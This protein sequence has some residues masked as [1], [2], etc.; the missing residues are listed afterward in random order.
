VHQASAPTDYDFLQE[1]SKSMHTPMR[2]IVS[3]VLSFSAL[4]GCVGGGASSASTS[5]GTVGSG[6]SPAAGNAVALGGQL[7]LGAAVYSVPS[8]THRLAVSVDRTGGSS[9]V[10]YASYSTA[11]GSAV[12]GTDF[13]T[14]AGMLQWNDG[15][16]APK[17][18]SVPINASA[19]ANKSF[20]VLLTNS[21]GATL[22][23]VTSATVTIAG[24][25][26]TSTGT[27][28][29]TLAIHVR[30][31]LLEDGSGAK[32]QL[33]GANVSGLEGTAVQG[34]GTSP[35]GFNNWADAGLGTEPD[36]SK[37]VAWKMNAVRIPLNETSWLGLACINPVSRATTNP[38]PGG[39][40]RATVK[41]SIADA[42]AA[43][44][45]VI[46]DLHWSAPGKYCATGQAQMAN[47]DNSV[48]F[49]TSIANSFKS[50]PAVIFELFNEPYGQGAYPVASSD[51]PILR[52]GGTYANFVHQDPATGA[53][54]TTSG[55][56]QA[57]GMQTML[58]AIRAAGATNVVLVS[59]MGYAE[60]LSHWLGEKPTDPLNQ[61]AA[62]WHAYPW[63]SDNSKPAGTGIG[64]QYAYA[65]AIL[66]AGIPV[67]ITETGGSALVPN[68]VKW[69]D[70][71]NASYL[72]WAW[73]P[74]GSSYLI[75]DANGT[76][77][78]FG[79]YYK[80]H[81]SCIAA[82]GSNCQ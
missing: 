22:G 70:A 42:N 39:N 26:T 60:D 32:V 21:S 63:S 66:A 2:H 19:S 51:W 68:I 47:S 52:D 50:D 44:L 33:R 76:P 9:G 61:M 65:A 36:W 59:T 55:S 41:K 5:N 16:A 78:G 67:V 7:E 62:V 81:L 12:A 8:N 29:S 13:T 45:Y 57:A 74:W 1:R 30:G 17:E 54:V 72:V 49:W 35:S 82:G 56:W 10:A 64:N 18:F 79:T 31:A 48:A 37:L 34:A 40:Y 11:N 6:A 14:S 3:M 38:D 46:L 4:V 71:A 73:D 43:G 25:G 58:N 27:G 20:S 24:A 80:A 28:S 15:D 69:A 77:T 75:S 23:T 53:M